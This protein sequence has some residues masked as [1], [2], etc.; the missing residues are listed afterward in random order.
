MRIPGWLKIPWSK[1]A[2]ERRMKERI[3]AL[4]KEWTVFFNTLIVEYDAEMTQFGIKAPVR[5]SIGARAVASAKKI[6]AGGGP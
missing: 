3:D 4:N 2:R 5:K 6:C 1:T